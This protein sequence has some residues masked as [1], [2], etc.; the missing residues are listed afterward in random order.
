MPA[1]PSFQAARVARFRELHQGGCFV[2]PNPWDIGSAVYLEH[3]G[4]PAVATTSGG[5]AFSRGLPDDPRVIPVE[6]MLAHARKIAAATTLPVNAD[7][8]DGFGAELDR[9]ADNVRMCAESGV[10]GLSIEDGT[11]DPAAPLYERAQAIE[12]LKVARAAIDASGTGVLLTARC[13]AWLVG[14]AHPLRTSLDRLTA[15]AAAGADCLYAPGV[16]DPNEIAEIVRAVA[17]KPVNVLLHKADPAISVARLAE[18]GVRRVSV[19]AALAR[20]AWGGFIRAVESLKTIGGF[21][22]SAHVAT[23]ADLHPIFERRADS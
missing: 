10:A 18:L 7:F 21:D 12:R 8:Q 5:F 4:F 17:P 16:Q 20:H 15:F 19:G 22:P 13:E 2:M 14:D 9:L 3:A 11:S 6:L 1:A 23:S